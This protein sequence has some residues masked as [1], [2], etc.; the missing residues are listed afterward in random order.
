MWAI[1]HNVV[2]N[3]FPTF[4][5][6]LFTLRIYS[7][8]DEHR[9]VAT[10]SVCSRFL[11]NL[12]RLWVVFKS[13]DLSTTTV[14]LRDKRKLFIGS[15]YRPPTNDLNPVSLHN[16]P[17]LTLSCIV[18][19]ARWRT[20][21]ITLWCLAVTSTWVISSGRKSQYAHR[22]ARKPHVRSLCN[23]CGIIMGISVV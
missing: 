19:K 9:S 6:T 12:L 13:L 10:T 21:Q 7:F 1:I 16:L 15:F 23:C 4:T 11:P 20:I 5:W 14:S 3:T 22:Y 17:I 18:W 2:S 8:N